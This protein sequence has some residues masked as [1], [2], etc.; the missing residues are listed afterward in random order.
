MLHLWHTARVHTAILLC[1]AQADA[2]AA[3]KYGKTPLDLAIK[4]QMVDVEFFLRRCVASHFFNLAVQR[5]LHC[6][7]LTQTSAATVRD[8]TG[9]LQQQDTLL[10]VVARLAS[11]HWP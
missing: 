10:L 5:Q 3:D 1:Y 11:N 9:R 4:K 7:S 2:T 6:H 8:T